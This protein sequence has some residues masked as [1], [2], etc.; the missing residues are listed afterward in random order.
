MKKY[1]RNQNYFIVDLL[2]KS[3]NKSEARISIFENI[4]ENY[5][6]LTEN[7]PPTII[8]EKS[9]WRWCPHQRTGIFCSIGLDEWPKWL[10]SPSRHCSQFRGTTST[11]EFFIGTHAWCAKKLFCSLKVVSFYIKYDFQQESC[12]G[13]SVIYKQNWFKSLLHIKISI[14][15]C[16]HSKSHCQIEF[17]KKKLTKKRTKKQK[18]HFI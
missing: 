7:D 6:A 3:K 18:T 5:L 8:K 9:I 14:I 2:D 12:I 15:I 11:D 10:L 1:Q 16:I 17:T 13:T 4:H